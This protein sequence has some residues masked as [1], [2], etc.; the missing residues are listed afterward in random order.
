MCNQ[1]R[2]TLFTESKNGV[3]EL[4]PPN[5]HGRPPNQTATSQFSSGY[6]SVIDASSKGIVALVV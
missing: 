5:H 1:I 6:I 3:M 2:F 4:E